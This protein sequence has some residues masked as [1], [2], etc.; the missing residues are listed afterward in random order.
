MPCAK[1]DSDISKMSGTFADKQK[2]D[3]RTMEQTTVATKKGWSWNS[4]LS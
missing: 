3:G 2:K 4:R 1:T